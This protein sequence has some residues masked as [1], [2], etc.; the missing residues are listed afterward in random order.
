M[1]LSNDSYNKITATIRSNFVLYTVHFNPFFNCYTYFVIIVGFAVFNGN[2]SLN[3]SSYSLHFFFILFFCQIKIVNIFYL[4]ERNRM[5]ACSNF[6]WC[7]KLCIRVIQSSLQN[8]WKTE[9]ECYFS[10]NKMNILYV[11]SNIVYNNMKTSK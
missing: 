8:S 5:T 1:S 10:S 3:R 4:A 7:S 9:K 11:Y 6:S 2:F